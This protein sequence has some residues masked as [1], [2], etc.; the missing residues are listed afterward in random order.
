MKLEAQIEVKAG[1]ENVLKRFSTNSVNM[2]N[3]EGTESANNEN[4][5]GLK[6]SQELKGNK[7]FK[8]NFIKIK[9]NVSEY[10]K[11]PFIFKKVN[12]LKMKL[13][14]Q[15]E[16]KAGYENHYNPLLLLFFHFLY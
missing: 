14:A 4:K 12:E 10:D 1:Y 16:V 3:I 7:K 8:F 5:G 11:L 6:T 9:G 2:N 15:I 13:E